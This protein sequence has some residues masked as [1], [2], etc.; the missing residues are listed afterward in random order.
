MV[1]VFVDPLC[2]LGWAHWPLIV[3]SFLAV[4]Q[5]YTFIGSG[6]MDVTKA[7]KFIWFGDIH[8]L[9]PYDLGVWGPL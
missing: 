3:F 5:C 1:L 7:Y 8:G 9:K 2:Y 4:Q 6:A